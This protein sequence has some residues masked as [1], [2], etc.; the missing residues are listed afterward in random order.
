[1]NVA[2]GNGVDWPLF[3]FSD[4]LSGVT[5]IDHSKLTLDLKKIDVLAPADSK[6]QVRLL[7]RSDAVNPSLGNPSANPAVPA[8]PYT[9]QFDLQRSVTP[10]FI[11]IQKLP[12]DDAAAK[13]IVLLGT[14]NNPAGWTHILNTG[15]SITAS[16]G[17]VVTNALD[18]QA[19]G[20]IGTSGARLNV[21]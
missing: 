19:S 18:I 5:I 7:T 14:I 21:D 20:G 16:G 1:K 17:N 15:G 11:D 6:P 8:V 13:D 10:G 4:S 3:T 12:P 2:S 9:L